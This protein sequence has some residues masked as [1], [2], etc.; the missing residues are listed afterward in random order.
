MLPLNVPFTG[1][2]KTGLEENAGSMRVT[3]FS[4]QIS[5]TAQSSP[6]PALLQNTFMHT[7][8]MSDADEMACAPQQQLMAPRGQ[9]LSAHLALGNP[10][11]AAYAGPVNAPAVPVA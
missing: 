2:F 8:L 5:T 6:P 4:A 1:S 7:S 11:C 3:T 10:G 9:I